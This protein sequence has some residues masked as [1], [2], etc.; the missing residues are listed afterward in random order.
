MKK[1]YLLLIALST[2]VFAQHNHPNP[3]YWQ[4]HA[5][6]KMEVKMDVE[7]FDY[8]GTQQLTYTNNSPD[9]LHQVFYHL[10]LRIEWLQA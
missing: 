7:N 10:Y 1:L 5:D 6:Y 3:G 8:A 9:T 2:S 4:Q